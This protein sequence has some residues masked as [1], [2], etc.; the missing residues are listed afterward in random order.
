MI[1]RPKKNEKDRRSVQIRVR[2]NVD[3]LCKIKR[4][5]AELGMTISALMRE[6]AMAYREPERDWKGFAWDGHE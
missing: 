2:M 3:E 4:K 6:G 5:A 1:G